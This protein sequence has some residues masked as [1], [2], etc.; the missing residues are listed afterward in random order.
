MIRISRNCT[1][2]IIFAGAFLLFALLASS[3]RSTEAEVRL[4]PPGLRPIKKPSLVIP[5]DFSYSNQPISFPNYLDASGK[6]AAGWSGKYVA[7]RRFASD[8]SAWIYFRNSDLQHSVLREAVGSGP[9]LRIWPVGTVMVI[10][11]FK[12]NAE[13]SKNERLV[14]IAVMSKTETQNNSFNKN[15][16]AA[17][18]NY[19]SFQPTRTPSITPAKVRE[20]HQCHSIAFHLTGDLVFTKFP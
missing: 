1:R 10:E 2:I 12:G 16:Y 17:N 3:L 6:P 11:I 15:F 19:A 20:C 4:S 5:A 13:L 14:E 7:T 18:W 8:R 9:A